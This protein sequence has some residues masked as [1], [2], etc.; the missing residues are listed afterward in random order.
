M[1]S[2]KVSAVFNVEPVELLEESTCTAR[3][4]RTGARFSKL[5]KILL[6]SS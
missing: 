6:S 4:R 5:L 3:L 1:K 2:T